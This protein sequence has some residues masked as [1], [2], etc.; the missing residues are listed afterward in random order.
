MHVSQDKLRALK[1]NKSPCTDFTN[2]KETICSTL[3]FPLSNMTCA[4]ILRPKMP[5]HISIMNPKK[6]TAEA[7]NRK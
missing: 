3:A 5:L 7:M 4:T 1:R 6:K 2:D